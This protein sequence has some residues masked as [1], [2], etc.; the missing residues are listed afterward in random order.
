MWAKHCR[1]NKM[2]TTPEILTVGLLVTLIILA[3]LFHIQAHASDCS[4]RLV[5]K[6]KAPDGQTCTREA[7]LTIHDNVIA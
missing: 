4:G 3:I 2:F 6:T 1:L 7:Q 5:S